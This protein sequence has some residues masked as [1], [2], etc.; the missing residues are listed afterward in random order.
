[1]PDRDALATTAR[2]RPEPD[3]ATVSGAHPYA[4]A[5]PDSDVDLRGAF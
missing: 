1:M 5:S 2:R 3:L 4:S